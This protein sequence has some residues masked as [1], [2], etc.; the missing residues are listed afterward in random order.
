MYKILTG[1]TLDVAE[2][3]NAEVTD[4]GVNAL[5]EVDIGDKTRRKGSGDRA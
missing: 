3:E 4:I 5:L 1:N 2:E